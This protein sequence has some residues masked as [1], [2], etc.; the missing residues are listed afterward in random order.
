MNKQIAQIQLNNN[1]ELQD[2]EHNNEELA[3]AI[4]TKDLEIASMKKQIAHQ[5]GHETQ[6][7]IPK[8]SSNLTN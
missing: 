5:I 8:S 3:N 2:P 4:K 1:R 6:A 7:G